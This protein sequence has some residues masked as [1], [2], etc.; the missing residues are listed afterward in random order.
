VF[1]PNKDRNSKNQPETQGATTN[2]F[3]IDRPCGTTE[4]KRESKNNNANSIV[5]L[6]QPDALSI[7]TTSDVEPYK[8]LQP[9]PLCEMIE[10]TIT[11]SRLWYDNR[12]HDNKYSKSS[13]AKHLNPRKNENSTGD[14][15]EY[16]SIFCAH[17]SQE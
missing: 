9:T 10:Q 17:P 14:T 1:S 4:S 16:V 13:L 2:K 11:T 3:N 7:T 12:S 8:Y 6:F 15:L 5:V